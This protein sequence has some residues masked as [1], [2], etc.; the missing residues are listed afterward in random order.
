MSI[1]S[2]APD[3]APRRALD[4]TPT[5]YA[6]ISEDAAIILAEAGKAPTPESLATIQAALDRLWIWECSAEARA[7]ASPRTTR[8]NGRLLDEYAEVQ[9]QHWIEVQS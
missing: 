7:T 3:I 4:Y 2:A 5:D 1:V 9:A 8:R 6:L